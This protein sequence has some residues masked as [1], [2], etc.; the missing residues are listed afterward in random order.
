MDIDNVIDDL[1]QEEESKIVFLILD[2]LGGMQFPGKQGTELEAAHTPNLDALV[3]EG[4]TGMIL[5]VSYGITPGSGPGH[6]A[7]FGYDPLEA[8]IGRGVLEAAGIGFPLTDRDVAVRGNF[9]TLDADGKITDRR[10]GRIPTEESSQICERLQAEIRQ[11]DNVEVIVRP[12]KEH[13]FLLVLRGDGLSGDLADTDPQETGVPPLDP[14]ALNSEAKRTSEITRRFVD[15]VR[16]V[17]VE[18]D[19]ANGVTLRGFAKHRPYKSMLERFKLRSLCIANY[20]MYR[21]VAFLVGMDL[22]PITADVATQ[23]D[24][25]ERKWADYDFFFLH[26]KYT[27]ARGEDGDFDAKV[28]VIEDVDALVPRITSLKPNV[29]VVTGDHSTPAAMRSHSWHPVPVLINAMTCRRDGN[30]HFGEHDCLRGGLGI[31]PSRH[32]MALALA[33]AG[34]L[35]KYGA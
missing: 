26:V 35:K 12:V 2:G 23:F 20:P 14:Q 21:G 17:L 18:E 11:I 27:D 4:T 16:Q 6:F 10:A 25:L 7:L 5:P 3:R 28:K 32:L 15:R 22:N 13:R 33:H 1:T 34:R 30:E 24:A 9:I 8:N 19:R 31:F 29:L